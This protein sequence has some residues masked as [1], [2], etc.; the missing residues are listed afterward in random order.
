MF[1]YIFKY[2]IFT[3]INFILFMIPSVILIMV[4][5]SSIVNGDTFELIY[6]MVFVSFLVLDGYVVQY[7]ISPNVGFFQGWKLG[8][9]SLKMYIK[10]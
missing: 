1:A 2:F 9:L 5:P 8:C 3:I 7:Q 4:L 10:P 6:G